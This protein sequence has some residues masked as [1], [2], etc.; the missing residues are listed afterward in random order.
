MTAN[1]YRLITGA[2]RYGTERFLTE[3]GYA[4]ADEKTIEEVLKITEGQYGHE[5]FRE[6]MG[7]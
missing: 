2:C 7:L 1:D 5:R 4:W 6:V 3:K